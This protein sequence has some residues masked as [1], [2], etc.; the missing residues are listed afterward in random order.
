METW[1]VEVASEKQKIEDFGDK[2]E[3]NEEIAAVVWMWF[4]PVKVHMLKHWSP[5][6]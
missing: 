3:G 2:K 1:N 6:W 4:G 5:V